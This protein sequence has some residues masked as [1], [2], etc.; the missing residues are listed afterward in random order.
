MQKEYQEKYNMIMSA[1]EDF[2]RAVALGVLVKRPLTAWHFLLPGIFIF[3][4]IRRSSEIKR[5]SS[6]FLF[7]RK[8]AID[9]A[10]DI[11]SGEDRKN[12]VS[13]AEEEI[14]QWLT[15]LQLYSGS[16]H[17]GQMEQIRLLIEHYSKLLHAEGNNYHSLVKSAYKTRGNYEA[18]LQQL[19]QAEQDVDKAI[20]EIR[21]ETQDIRERLRAEQV[22]VEE[23][24]KKQV[25][26]IFASMR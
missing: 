2:A 4:F 1:E 10:L 6:L 8:F 16:L 21:G 14:R 17:R 26:K 15:S 13:R 22:Q 24:R 5:Y 3:D 12:R 25:K 9:V 18:Y 23:L 11:S 20:A 7:P 19:A